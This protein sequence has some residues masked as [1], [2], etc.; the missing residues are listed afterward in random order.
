[1]G[2]KVHEDEN[3]S[4]T[5]L[6]TKGQSFH[7]GIYFVFKDITHLSK[8]GQIR[9]NSSCETKNDVTGGVN[10]LKGQ[11]RTEI[12]GQM[13]ET[14]TDMEGKWESGN[15]LTDNLNSNRQTSNQT[16]QASS[17]DRITK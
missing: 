9:T 16:N 13:S 17:I 14:V 12:P 10:T 4:K 6:L 5:H 11:L 15:G 7:I 1:M 8:E 3:A 2:G